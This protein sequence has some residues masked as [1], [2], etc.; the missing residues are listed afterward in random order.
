MQILQQCSYPLQLIPSL[1]NDKQSHQFQKNVVNEH[2]QALLIV[3]HE[4]KSTNIS[5]LRL[6]LTTKVKQ[7]ES[8]WLS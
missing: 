7:K 6:T 5:L 3:E 4:P 1:E 8:E 2:H